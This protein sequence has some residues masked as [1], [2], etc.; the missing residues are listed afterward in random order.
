MTP[1]EEMLESARFADDAQVL[2]EHIG[3]AGHT[4][5]VVLEATYGWAWAVNALQAAGGSVHHL[6]H[7]LG[8]KALPTAGE[9]RLP[10]RRRSG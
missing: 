8:V 5:A 3:R 4:P 6:A 2:A 9:E 1:D 7:P 10:R